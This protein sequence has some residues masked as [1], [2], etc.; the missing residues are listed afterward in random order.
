MGTTNDSYLKEFSAPNLT[1]RL[2][3]GMTFLSQVNHIPNFLTPLTLVALFIAKDF[4]QRMLVVNPAQRMTADAALAHQ[5]IQDAAPKRAL[6]SFGS[7]RDGIRNM[8]D[9]KLRER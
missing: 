1:F 7:V 8:K 3:S 2:R 9:V 4:V 6:K 5:W